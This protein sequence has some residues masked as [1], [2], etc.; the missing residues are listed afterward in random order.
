MSVKQVP[1]TVMQ[2]SKNVQPEYVVQQIIS[3]FP[4]WEYVHFDDKTMYEYM[5]ENPCEEFPQAEKM[6]KFFKFGAHKTDYFRYYYLYLNGG[7]YLDSDLMIEKSILH[8]I[9]E[10]DFVTVENKRIKA[11]FQGLL[12]C[13]PGNQ[14]IRESLSNLYHKKINHFHFIHDY[15]AACKDMLKI[16]N[17][18]TTLNIKLYQERY[19]ILEGNDYPR[20]Q[21]AL[22]MDGN[23][24]LGVHYYHQKKIPQKPLMADGGKLIIGFL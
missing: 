14:I 19:V 18:N 10:Y 21:A 22:I 12:S 1:P 23:D 2:C 24:I 6:L 15:H 16:I 20:Q 11:A 8:D 3:H 4:G 9:A 5:V 17:R 13:D 7:V